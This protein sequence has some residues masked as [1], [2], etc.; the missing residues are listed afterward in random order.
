ML[1]KQSKDKNMKKQSN[2]LKP[3]SAAINMSGHILIRDKDTGEVIINKRNAIHYG[4]MARVVA[5]ALNNTAGAYI[6]YMAFGNGGTSIDTSGG[7]VIY[8]SPR[9]SE[10]Y[11][12]SSSLYNKTHHKDIQGPDVVNPE[13]NKIEVITGPSYTD[14]KMTAT[15]G[16]DEPSGQEIFDNSTNNDGDYVFD[17]LGVFTYPADATLPTADAQFDTSTMLTHVIFHPV[18]K[19]QNRVIEIIYTIRIQLS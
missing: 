18:Q 12:A 6:N 3:E 9:V 1:E 2:D 8:K 19:S 16:Y 11:E 13:V 15:L 17:E 7:R 10:S 4:N 5:L 14:L